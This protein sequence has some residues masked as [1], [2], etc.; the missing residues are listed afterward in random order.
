MS[1][2]WKFQLKPGIQF[3]KMP[4]GARILYPSPQHGNA[5]LYA[6]IPDTSETIS[7][8]HEITVVGTGYEFD[9]TNQKPLGLV[10]LDSGTY[11][12]HVFEKEREVN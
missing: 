5:V 1:E 2:V 10:S 12:L 3:I 6:L 11:M 4:R 8:M 9:S 7:K